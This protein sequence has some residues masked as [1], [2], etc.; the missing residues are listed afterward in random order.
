MLKFYTFGGVSILGGRAPPGLRVILTL[1]RR[2]GKGGPTKLRKKLTPMVVNIIVTLKSR[3]QVTQGHWKWYHWK[4]WATVWWRNHDDN[5]VKPFP[6][7]TRTSR[8]DKRRGRPICCISIARQSCWRAID[9]FSYVYWTLLQL[10]LW[11]IFCQRRLYPDP[12]VCAGLPRADRAVGRKAS[13]GP[14]ARGGSTL[15]PGG[16]Q[17]PQ[18]FW[19]QQQKYVFLKSRLILCSGEINT[20]IS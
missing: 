16:A 18:I 9:H 3:L 10:K 2:E 17:A 11:L 5:Y 14:W 19:F 13:P 7:N 20:C 4:S 12:C 1:G 15:G 6:F 8:T